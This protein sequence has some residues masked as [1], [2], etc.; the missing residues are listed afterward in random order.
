MCGE[1]F[2]FCPP[3][4]L[5]RS[6]SRD[7]VT[8]TPSLSILLHNNSSFASNSLFFSL[9]SITVARNFS[10]PHALRDALLLAGADDALDFFLSARSSVCLLALVHGRHDLSSSLQLS[11][12]TWQST[13]RKFTETSKWVGDERFGTEC[14]ITVPGSCSVVSDVGSRATDL[15]R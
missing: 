5:R 15:V 9:V 8:S 7:S 14:R 1:A 4:I 3:I 6:F 2:I 12:M 10:G 13:E 11:I